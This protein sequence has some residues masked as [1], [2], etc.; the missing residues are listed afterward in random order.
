[1]NVKTVCPRAPDPFNASDAE[2]GEICFR[3]RGIM[4]GYLANPR[5]GKEHMA[6]MEKK[7]AEAIDAEGWMHSGDKGCMDTLGLVKITG[8]YKYGE[9]AIIAANKSAACP[10]NAAKIQKFKILPRDF[11]VETDEFTPTLKLKRSVVCKIHS[12]AIEE[13]Y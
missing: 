7:N 1:M 8:R 13:M 3:G 4:H 11:S 5:F 6:E 9:A 12:A 10:S 2:Q